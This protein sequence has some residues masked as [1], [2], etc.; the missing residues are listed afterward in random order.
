MFALIPNN[1]KTKY[2]AFIQSMDNKEEFSI[3][4]VELERDEEIE[5]NF[6]DAMFDDG[7]PVMK[8]FRRMPKEMTVT[9]IKDRIYKA[10]MYEIN[11][12][13]E[14]GREECMECDTCEEKIFD[15][16]QECDNEC[17]EL[18]DGECLNSLCFCQMRGD[19]QFQK[20]AFC[21]ERIKR[22]FYFYTGNGWICVMDEEQWIS[23]EKS[24]E[25][26]WD[27]V[28]ING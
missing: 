16:V 12:G 25:D 2:E 27:G 4:D 26:T 3:V 14:Q 21:E 6:N 20:C 13:Q 11:I 17:D 7:A 28:L 23:F 1:D 22:E 8:C 19:K 9:L 24:S 5:G 10:I 15:P 18:V